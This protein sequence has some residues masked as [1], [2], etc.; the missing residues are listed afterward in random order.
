MDS[1]LLMFGIY[2]VLEYNLNLQNR[3]KSY[4]IL[5]IVFCIV[6]YIATAIALIDLVIF[7]VKIIYHFF[8][9]VKMKHT[10]K[11]NSI[12]PEVT[13]DSKT[14]HNLNTKSD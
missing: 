2:F 12:V 7:S 4:T 10:K 5:F 11:K 8:K 14:D 6:Q 9:W 1:I 3:P 13:D